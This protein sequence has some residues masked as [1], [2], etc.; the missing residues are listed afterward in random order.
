MILNRDINYSI[1]NNESPWIGFNPS[2]ESNTQ[3]SGYIDELAIWKRS[4]NKIEVLQLYIY[5]LDS[6]N[7]L[8]CEDDDLIHY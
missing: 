6:I 7:S 3:F 1:S 4:L 8:F 5:K 2:G